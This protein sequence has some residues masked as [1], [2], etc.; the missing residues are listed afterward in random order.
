MVS[1]G[2]QVNHL[3]IDGRALGRLA[4]LAQLAFDRPEG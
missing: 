1:V 2:V 3:F 4:E